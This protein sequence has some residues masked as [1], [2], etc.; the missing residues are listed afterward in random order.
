MTPNPTLV[1]LEYL[2]Q[3]GPKGTPEG[4]I[5]YSVVQQPAGWDISYRH[6]PGREIRT[7]Y[8]DKDDLTSDQWDKL[9]A[10]VKEQRRNG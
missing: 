10:T 5:I 2:R 9:I 6:G 7:L 4:V 8:V 3:H 1:A